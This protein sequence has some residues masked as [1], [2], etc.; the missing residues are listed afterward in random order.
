RRADR[1]AAAHRAGAGRM[2]GAAVLV[3]LAIVAVGCDWSLHRMQEQPRCALHEPTALFPDG[4]CD[5]TP[6]DGVVGFGATA[7][8]GQG[9][10]RLARALLER[11]RDRFERFCAPCHGLEGNGDSVIARDMRLRRPPSL[12][13]DARVRLADAKIL[14]IIAGGYGVMPSYG[15]ALAARDRWAIVQYLRVLQSREIALDALSPA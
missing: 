11:G 12:L 5:R 2:R 15:D 14:V 9:A 3:A 10:P 1:A 7:A 4:A 6:P 13:D 8:A